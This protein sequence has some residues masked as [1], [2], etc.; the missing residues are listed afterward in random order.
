M[1]ERFRPTRYQEDRGEKLDRVV[2]QGGLL[3]GAGAGEVLPEHA[4][5][6]RG[7]AIVQ[8]S[9]VEDLARTGDEGVSFAEQVLYHAVRAL[10]DEEEPRFRDDER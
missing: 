9:L 1:R 2:R 3:R 7:M 6:L 10:A 4:A 5:L 8:R